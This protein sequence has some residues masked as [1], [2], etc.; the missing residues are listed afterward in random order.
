[1]D[2]ILFNPNAQN[3]ADFLKGFVARQDILGFLLHQLRQLPDGQAARHHL[4]VAPRGFGKTSLL[5]RTAIGI[6]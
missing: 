6:R 3:E 4:I 2:L 1:M 5:R